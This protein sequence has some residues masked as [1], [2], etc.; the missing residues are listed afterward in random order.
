MLGRDGVRR[1]GQAGYVRLELAAPRLLPGGPPGC[2]INT[3]QSPG[4]PDEVNK[5]AFV[6]KANVPRLLA[7]CHPSQRHKLA[8]SHPMARACQG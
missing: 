7:S 2:G 3:V 1:S 6:S 5:A 8:H 4:L